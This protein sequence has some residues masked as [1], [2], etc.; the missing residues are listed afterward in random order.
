MTSQQSMSDQILR[1]ECDVLCKLLCGRTASAYVADAYVAA[2]AVR[3][4]LTSPQSA[5]DQ[6]VAVFSR[7]LRVFALL[8][9]AYSAFFLRRGL[10]R[11]KLALLVGILECTP[12]YA[13]QFE[14]QGP[15]WAGACARLGL[16]GMVAAATV[17]TAAAVL[18]PVH[19]TLAVKTR[20]GWGASWNR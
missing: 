14:P 16:H 5:M 6:W 19:L 8:G 15:G 9:D 12:P 11:R 1:R 3:A 20:L 13:D 2:H 17:S 18:G 7:Q 4:E 10:L